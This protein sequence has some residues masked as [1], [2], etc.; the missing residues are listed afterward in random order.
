M[1]RIFRFGFLCLLPLYPFAPAVGCTIFVL[2]DG[3]RTMFFNNEDYSN[4]VTR[5]WFLPATKK[6]YGTAYVGFNDGWA[7]GGV[8]DQGLAFDWVAGG[9][10]DYKPAPALKTL[11]GNPA[12]RMLE[13]CKTVKE[14]I[15]FYN[16]FLETGFGAGRMLVADKTG[17]S[18]IIGSKN[19]SLSFDLSKQSRGFGFGADS[20][21]KMLSP[22]LG[23]SMENG[24]P[25]LQACRQ[26][27]MYATKYTTVYDL[28]AGKIF[29]AS[30]DDVGRNNA[31]DLKNG[32]LSLDL[33]S[34]FKKGPHYYD[35]PMVEKQRSQPAV[36]LNPDMK[37]YLW[38]GYE[39]F[40]ADKPQVTR[41]VKEVVTDARKGSLREALFDPEFWKMIGPA[42][43]DMQPELEKL[44]ELLSATLLEQNQS[45]FL[46]L[47]DYQE[48][49]VL[50]RFDFDAK[51]LISSIK[52]EAAEMK[53]GVVRE[54]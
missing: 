30:P 43:K 2:T 44:G 47:M 3:K 15:A 25:I 8:N 22:A 13:S 42:Q 48:A 54:R 9:D 31:F 41:I 51:N 14:A 46:Y 45:S 16:Q 21:K 38:E 19:G 28:V 53:I 35:I 29:L 5:I 20:L 23:P 7:Q 10:G 24:L 49:T 50:Q 17:A 4:P 18:V 26:D 12:E 32:N 27:G 37:R 11:Q 52:S 34:E 6:F 36:S 33:K 40:P 39:P 1:L